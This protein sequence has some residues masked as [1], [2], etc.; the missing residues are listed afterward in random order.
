MGFIPIFLTL[1]GFVFLFT[2]VVST[3]IKNKRKA[4]DMS[5]DKLKESLSLKEDMIASR[6]SL[7]RLENEYLS[8]KEADR[9][10]SKVALSQTKL[11]L[12]QYNRLLKKRPYSFVASLIGYHPI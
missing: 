8:K 12:F 5:F 1:G 7:V 10:P 9:I 2:I 11:Y 6:E 4:F 3:S